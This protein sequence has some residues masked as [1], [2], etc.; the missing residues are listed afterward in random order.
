[1][2]GGENSIMAFL[3]SKEGALGLLSMALLIFQGTA[4]SLTLRF[5]RCPH[6]CSAIP[7]MLPAFSRLNEDFPPS[8]IASASD[9]HVTPSQTGTPR[10]VTGD[11]ILV[12][13]AVT[14]IV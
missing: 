13:S 7:P 1:M 12:V 6:P 3:S 14:D 2:R 10:N 9:N 5:S 4:L 8:W 11:L